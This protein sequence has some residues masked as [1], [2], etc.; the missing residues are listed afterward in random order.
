MGHL[1]ALLAASAQSFNGAAGTH[2]AR[3]RARGTGHRRRFSQNRA[4]RTS[5]YETIEEESYIPS[6]VR[7]TE[8]SNIT[9]ETSSV[10]IADS[11]YVVDAETASMTSD[12]DDEH[13]IVSMRNYY[14][15]QDE[16]H[17]TVEESKRTWEDT[18]FSLFALQCELLACRRSNLDD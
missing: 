8:S 13:G 5:V 11:I 14:A 6:P 17:E 16:A 18:P 2:S 10:V 7:Q 12:W 3:V 15:L 4:S 1:N 9:S